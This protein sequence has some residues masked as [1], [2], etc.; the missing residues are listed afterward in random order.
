MTVKEQIHKIVDD[1][2][3]DSSFTEILRELAFNQMIKEGIEDVKSGNVISH[4]QMEE[5]IASWRQ[6]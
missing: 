6:K 4:E 1:Q 3:D 5:E 2:P